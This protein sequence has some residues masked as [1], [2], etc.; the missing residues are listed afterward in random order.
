MQ[1]WQTS[2][3]STN[4]GIELGPNSIRFTKDCG[5]PETYGGNEMPYTRFLRSIKWQKHVVDIFGEQALQ[6]VLVAAKAE[7]EQA[8]PNL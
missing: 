5:T 1:R 2:S 4:Y 7:T 6:S 3:G 8:L